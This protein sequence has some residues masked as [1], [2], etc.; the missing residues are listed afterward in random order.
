MKKRATKIFGLLLSF[1]F[2]GSFAPMAFIQTVAHAIS[3]DKAEQVS[4]TTAPA[5]GT[6]IPIR[7][8]STIFTPVDNQAPALASVT[9]VSGTGERT[10]GF[11]VQANGV[12]DSSG[13]KSVSFVVYRQAD[14]LSKAITYIAGNSGDGVW[15]KYIDLSSLGNKPGNYIVKVWA[16]DNNNNAGMI[17]S[18]NINYA[19]AT[20]S[21]SDEIESFVKA[22]EAQ[23]GKRY[24]RGG[25]GPSVFDCSGL[26]YYALQ[27]SGKG[28]PYMTSRS[29]A[30]SAYPQVDSMDDLQRGDVVCFRG[31]VGIYLGGGTMV[32]ASSSQGKV[33]MA[34][35]IQSSSYWK[36]NFICGRRPL[37]R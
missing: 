25:K 7:A 21:G 35:N 33:R 37:Q 30:E 16:C 24:V 20:L 23:M 22:A 18:A 34:Y 9:S 8:G 6:N 14:G 32:D 12:A 3:A 1:V 27:S 13:V 11:A 15:S 26:V 17:G 19:D 10:A 36:R 29:W 4:Y 5:S 31:H 2:M 28:I